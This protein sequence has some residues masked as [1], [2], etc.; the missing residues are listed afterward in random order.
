M[1]KQAARLPDVRQLHSVARQMLAL[2]APSQHFTVSIRWDAQA[3]T[4]RIRRASLCGIEIV[5]PTTWQGQPITLR[6]ALGLLVHELCH[7]LQDQYAIES[8]RSQYG[9]DCTVCNI[10]EDINV[11][12]LAATLYPSAAGWLAEVN[13]P[14]KK[15][16]LKGWQQAVQ[17]I[18]PRASTYTAHELQ[19][20]LFCGA[21]GNPKQR[22]T[23]VQTPNRRLT[24]ILAAVGQAAQQRAN[25]FHGWFAQ[26]VLANPEL[27]TEPPQ[28]PAPET[29]PP[30]PTPAPTPSPTQGAPAPSELSGTGTGQ[31]ASAANTAEAP[32]AGWTTR[33]GFRPTQC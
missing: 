20:A 10:I 27:C 16:R 5:L 7:P 13:A 18:A 29:P 12:A 28:P 8:I 21:Y 24:E 30:P 23:T 2:L 9:V 26:L 32:E 33:A 6:Q 22:W 17:A 25:Q 1:S 4:A 15:L 11:E 3:P 14:V 31:T 19:D